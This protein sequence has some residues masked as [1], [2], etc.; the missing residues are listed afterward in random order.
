M[1]PLQACFEVATPKPAYAWAFP[2][3]PE[4]LARIAYFFDASRENPPRLE[5]WLTESVAVVRDSRPAAVRS[6]HVLHGPTLRVYLAC[7]R[8]LRADA[9]ARAVEMPADAVRDELQRLRD[10]RLVIEL[11]GRWVGLAV[12]RSRPQAA[13]IAEPPPRRAPL[14]I[15][16]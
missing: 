5:F 14:P 2:L 3:P 9:I 8:G 11:D 16:K 7:A 12:C 6:T 15:L 13:A 4:T 10:L 1:I